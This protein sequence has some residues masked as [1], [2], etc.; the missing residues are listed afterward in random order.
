MSC[1]NYILTAH[2]ELLGGGLRSS[3][4]QRKTGIDLTTIEPN[5]PDENYSEIFIDE[6]KLGASKI[7]V[8]KR[9]PL[10][11]WC[12]ALR[13]Y[14]GLSTMIVPEMFRNKG[15]TGYEIMFGNTSDINEY[16]QFDFYDYC[17]Y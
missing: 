17:W 10:Q 16:V 15:R 8:R 14:C 7:I 5:L 6:S 1:R 3:N 13:Y 4:V 2:P 11:L 12:Y 9:V